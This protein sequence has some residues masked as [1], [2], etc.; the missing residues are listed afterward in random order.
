MDMLRAV[1][2]VYTTNIS[3][4]R[5]WEIIFELVFLNT[6]LKDFVFLRLV[7]FLLPDPHIPKVRMV[8]P[9]CIAQKKRS[10]L[11]QLSAFE[12]REISFYQ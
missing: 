6:T 4:L 3:I 2:L 8:V 10:K 9:N 12:I 5:F 7:L 1:K 11:G